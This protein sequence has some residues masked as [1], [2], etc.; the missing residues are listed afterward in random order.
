[1][2]KD[3]GWEHVG[4]FFNGWQYFR[5]AFVPGEMMDIYSDAE[6]KIGKYNR[7]LLFLVPFIPLLFFSLISVSANSWLFMQVIDV[8]LLVIYFVSFFKLWQRIKD[9]KKQV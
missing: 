6:S 4:Q 5:K 1:M 2:F 9:L 8:F 7:L 3:A